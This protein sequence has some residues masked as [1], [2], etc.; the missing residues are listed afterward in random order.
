MRNTLSCLAC[1]LSNVGVIPLGRTGEHHATRIIIDATEWQEEY[2]NGAL[3]LL[4]CNPNG[5]VY[6]AQVETNGYVLTWN[7]T[8]DETAV[9][10][11]GEIE[12]NLS[13][14]GAVV[15]SARCATQIDAALSQNADNPPTGTPEW[16]SELLDSIDNIKDAGDTIEAAKTATNAATNA[17]KAATAAAEASVHAPYIDTATQHWMAWS[18]DK[19]A[20]ADTGVKAQGPEGEPGDDGITPHIGAN[21]NWFIG[22]TD[23]GV[24]AQGPAG[25]NGTGSGTVTGVKVDEQTYQPDS[26]GVVTLPNM[27]GG[28]ADSVAW[29]NVTG[30]PSTYPP[31]SHSHAEYATNETVNQLSEQMANYRTAVDLLANS[32][33]ANLVNQ[34][35]YK[36]WTSESGT[37]TADTK[38]NFAGGY[39]I[40]RW[41]LDRG[42]LV[43]NNGNITIDSLGNESDFDQN[44]ENF[45]RLHGKTVTIAGKTS[46]GLFCQTFVMGELGYGYSLISGK[47]NLFSIPQRHVVLRIINGAIIAFEWIELYEGSYTIETLPPYVPKRYAAELAECQRYLRPFANAIPGRIYEP[48]AIMVD[49]PLNP[50]MR[51][52]GL[53]TV[54]FE[55]S[56]ADAYT[57]AGIQHVVTSFQSDCNEYAAKYVFYCD[58]ELT[59]GTP[60]VLTGIKGWISK[61]L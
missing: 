13:A 37:D 47:L 27:G 54:T 52:D 5:A 50:P 9:A 30:K 36:K 56:S 43:V 51:K 11:K 3:A 20:Y 46:E 7:V 25:Q 49:M 55:K 24:K 2:P 26:S 53:M 22:S 14:G 42:T 29:D 28:V 57:V 19:S 35:G 60:A 1:E 32:D 41:K 31:E 44:L 39:T 4:V 17:A 21:G 33:F 59:V 10:G 6:P 8:R 18:T 48:H 12:L 34:R 23:T 40:D 61:E 58:A 15:K 16:V 45:D 38:Y